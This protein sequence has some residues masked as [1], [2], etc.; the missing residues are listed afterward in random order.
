LFIADYKSTSYSAAK[1]AESVGLQDQAT[2]YI[3]GLSKLYP[4][5]RVVGVV[6]EVL[7]KRQSVCTATR[8][9]V[10]TRGPNALVEYEQELIGLLIDIE[11]RLADL[12]AG[13]PPHV[14][15]PR[16]G[17]DEAY[18]GNSPYAPIYRVQLPDDM[19]WVPPGYKQK[20]VK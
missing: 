1:M 14:L 5:E 9:V 10:V 13:W 12:A 16:N 2:M 20:G 7:Y 19:T 8:S 3:M 17:A 6:P 11:R 18:F 4:H 15:F